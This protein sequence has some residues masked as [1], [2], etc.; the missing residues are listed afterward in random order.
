MKEYLNLNGNSGIATYEI[1]D[2]YIDIE[3]ESGGIYL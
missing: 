1:H 3:F 2:D